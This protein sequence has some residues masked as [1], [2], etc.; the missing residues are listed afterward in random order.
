L[1]SKTK[2]NV[3]ALPS[4]KH[5]QQIVGESILESAENNGLSFAYSCRTGRCSSCRCKIISGDTVPL[6]QEL[7]LS[8]EEKDDGW[9]LT[10]ARSAISDLEIEIDDLG[11][12]NLPKV[13]SF[14][15]KISSIE[16]VAEHIMRVSLR[17]PPASKLD[18]LPGQYIDIT[19]PS[20]ETRSYSV[21]NYFIDGN[22]DLHIRMV[23]KGALSEYWFLEA[24]INDLLR[25]KGPFGS[26][27]LRSIAAQDVVFLA[28][29]TGIAPI[30][31]MIES[32]ELLAPEDYPR[33]M[34][35]FWGGRTKDDL[36]CNPSS[37]LK[38]LRYVP[39][40][41]QSA[42][43]WDGQKGYVQDVFLSE[44]PDLSKCVVYACG[45]DNMIRSSF[46]MLVTS[47][48]PENKFYSDAFLPSKPL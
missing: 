7:G 39:V 37:Y 3:V 38:S 13:R 30:K 12:I 9:I 31:A 25:F 14:P 23:D 29:G 4:G 22:L 40:L 35:V 28:T 6:V 18:I 33:S 8:H 21:A 5:F 20:G 16:R 46:K 1:E 26:F 19:G 15:C 45:S 27:F 41:S 11:D 47:G 48:L 32:V 17:L 34:T 24:K 2:I 43:D 42:K 44:D 10:C 36:Y